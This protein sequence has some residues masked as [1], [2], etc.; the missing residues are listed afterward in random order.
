[1]AH[2]GLE[3]S[4]HIPLGRLESNPFPDSTP[5]FFRGLEQLLNRAMGGRLTILRPYERLPKTERITIDGADHVPH[6]SVP[7]RYVELVRTFA[8]ECQ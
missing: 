2:R 8:T 1:M 6:I 4:S 5:E 3:G 7:A